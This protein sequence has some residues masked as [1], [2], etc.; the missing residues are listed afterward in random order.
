[1]HA[2]SKFTRY[3]KVQLKDSNMKKTKVLGVLLIL[4]A[5]S[6]LVWGESILSI[7]MVV[8]KDG[9]ATLKEIKLVDGRP[10]GYTQPGEYLFVFTDS[11]GKTVY[12]V[13]MSVDYNLYRDPPAATNSVLVELKVPYKSEMNYLKFYRKTTL[14]ISQKINLCDNNG[15]CDASQESYLTCPGDCPLGGLDG[16]CLARKDGVCDPDCADGTDPDCAKAQNTTLPEASKGGLDLSGYLFY[17]LIL[18]IVILIVLGVLFALKKAPG[19]SKKDDS[20]FM[21]EKIDLLSIKMDE[22]LRR[23]TAFEESQ[24]QSMRNAK[25]SD[26]GYIQ[27]VYEEIDKERGKINEDR[28]MLETDV[29]TMDRELAELADLKKARVKELELLEDE[30]AKIALEKQELERQRGIMHKDLLSFKGRFNSIKGTERKVA[31]YKDIVEKDTLKVEQDTRIVEADTVLVEKDL[32]LTDADRKA[33]AEEERK[34]ELDRKRIDESAAEIE[35]ERKEIISERS[36][37][38]QEERRILAERKKIE[39]ERKQLDNMVKQVKQMLS[40]KKDGPD[41]QSD[42]K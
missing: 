11:T 25:G 22:L 26:P 36:R 14:L 21:Q 29:S 24:R 10:T 37:I 2:A 3:A 33:M 42:E 27:Q 4:L 18:F 9:S 5:V 1:V 30:R 23:E 40:G 28:K 7:S 34:I 38:E 39:T 15:K 16:L 41:S 19:S 20:S 31:D 13:N 17:G 35:K 32:V 12:K 8:Q 6:G